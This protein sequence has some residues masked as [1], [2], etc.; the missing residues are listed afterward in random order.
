MRFALTLLHRNLI[1][2]R[3]DA[4]R[5]HVLLVTPNPT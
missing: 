4:R 1:I 2:A 3:A 5:L